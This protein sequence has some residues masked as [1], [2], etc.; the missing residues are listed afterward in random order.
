MHMD[1]SD[2]IKKKMPAGNMTFP[3]L[4]GKSRWKLQ[5]KTRPYANYITAGISYFLKIILRYQDYVCDL[6][7]LMFS[8]NS[9]DFLKKFVHPGLWF[10]TDLHTQALPAKEYELSTTETL[11]GKGLHILF[12]TS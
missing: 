8:P 12:R 9:F 2:W 1:F 6:K 11:G 10:S 7:K 3:K 4:S 5:S